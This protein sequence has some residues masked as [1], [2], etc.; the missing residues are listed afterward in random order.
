MGNVIEVTMLGRFTLKQDGMEAPAAV[1]L[2][3]RS[4]RLWTLTAYLILHRERG[5]SA[6]E[7]IDLL[8][9]EAEGG[10]PLSTLQNNVSRVR[11]ALAEFGFEQAKSMIRYDGGYYRWAPADETQ[12]DAEKFEQLAKSAMVEENRETAIAEAQRAIALYTGD[13]LPDSAMELWCVNLNAYYRSLYIR[14]CKQTVAW[15]FDENRLAEAERICTKVIELDPTA[16]ELSVYLMRALT[17]GKQPQKALEHY[18]YI[19]QLYRENYGVAPSVALETEKAA[20]IQELYGTDVEENEIRDFLLDERRE[21][22]AFLCDNNSFREIINLHLRAMQRENTRAQLVVIRLDHRKNQPER[23]AIYMKQLEQ[24]LQNTLRSGDPFT[25]V[26]TNQFW[27][28]L[29]GA[30][31]EN[32]HSVMERVMN[33]LHKDYPKSSAL[34][35]KKV[36][37]MRSLQA[38]K[39]D[40]S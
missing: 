4:W 24:T 15:L 10:N 33:R 18:E 23:R 19:W 31:T 8:W 37:D 30:T 35:T 27:V 9:P 2:T 36:L 1:S 25:R 40:E 3:G 7:L 28:L 34:F 5:V 17:R 6:Q 14:L 16:E 38:G 22:G 26:G 21:P 39:R 13:F 20:A 11:T 32:G 12:L 29:P